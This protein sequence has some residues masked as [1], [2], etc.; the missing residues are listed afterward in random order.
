MCFFFFFEA[1]EDKPCRRVTEAES[2]QCSS[3][4][5]LL[6]PSLSQHYVSSALGVS[7]CVFTYVGGGGCS[8]MNASGPDYFH[9]GLG[10]TL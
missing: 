7:L 9:S 8:I 1:Y 2:P 3:L 4:Y 5:D 10:M 6:S